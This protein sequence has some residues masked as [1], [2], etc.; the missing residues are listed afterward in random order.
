MRRHYTSL[1]LLLVSF[2]TVPFGGGPGRALVFHRHGSYGVHVH[3]VEA[4]HAQIAGSSAR[5][6]HTILPG[7][8]DPS[9]PV[10]VVGTIINTDFVSVRADDVSAALRDARLMASVID[11]AAILACN[12]ADGIH[13]CLT[14]G[15]R[16]GRDDEP[17]WQMDI[18]VSDLPRL[19]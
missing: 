9:G 14:V 4:L 18:F 6:G 5:F 1:V 11:S 3:V 16:A 7:L 13:V 8:V 2:Q 19:I 12:A 15:R 10:T 17:A